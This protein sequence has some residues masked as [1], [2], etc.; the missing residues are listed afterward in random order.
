[1]Q[2]MSDADILKSLR[3]QVLDESEPLA[4][5]LRKCLA[6]GEVTGSDEL[7]AWATSE[8]KGYADD[9]PLPEYRKIVAQLY[10]NRMGGN[11]VMTHHTT[12]RTEIP[13][14]I[15]P[16]IPERVYLRQSVGELQDAATSSRAT[17]TMSGPTFALVADEWTRRLDE[18]QAILAL[19][20]EVSTSALAGVVDVVRTT[21]VEIVIALAKD[22]PLDS[23]PTRAK[24]DAA[25]HLHINSNDD[26][27]I[28][29]AGSNTGVV[30][31]GAGSTQIQNQ[32]APMD[33]VPVIAQLRAALSDVSDPD[34]KAD[35]EQA[36]D[37]FEDATSADAPDFEKVK[38]RWGI[39]ERIATA[40][41]VAA[42]TQAVKDGA[43]VVLEHLQLLA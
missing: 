24:V 19:Y 25:V 2:I 39:L 4:G 5:L 14:D 22:V 35:A 6:L 15:R 13:S 3:S 12:S 29:I 40:L 43:P 30:G 27:S 32:T 38:R 16:L 26:N 31:Q 33:L 9:A 37:D 1:M 42:M 10:S 20:Y 21:L 23:L 17:V 36:I 18:F 8:L 7:R 28:N 34:Q 41:G 11:T